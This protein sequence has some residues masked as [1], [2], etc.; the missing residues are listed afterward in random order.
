MNFNNAYYQQP[1]YQQQPM[2]PFQ[3]TTQR[4]SNGIV[5]VQGEAGAKAYVVNTGETVILMDSENPF[6]Y[7][8]SVN[9]AGMPFLEKY[10]FE[11]VVDTP[12]EKT[13]DQQQEFI[14]RDEFEKRIAELSSQKNNHRKQQ[15][16]KE[17]NVDA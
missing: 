12:Q 16:R 13:Q 7:I 5:W 9:Q 11:K 1:F 4:Q 14:T 10:R 8:K 2:Y 6:F 15:P 17:V 3:Q